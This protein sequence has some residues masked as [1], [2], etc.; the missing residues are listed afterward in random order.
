MS[1]SACSAGQGPDTRAPFQ[2]GAALTKKSPRLLDSTEGSI[3]RVLLS[4]SNY[5]AN[6]FGPALQQVLAS[7]P[8]A[9]RL[10]ILVAPQALDRVSNWLKQS[11][12]GEIACLVEAPDELAFSLWTQDLFLA[13]EDARLELPLHFQRYQDLSA[14]KHLASGAGLEISS[15]SI[16]FEGGNVIPAGDWLLIGKDLVAQNHGDALALARQIDPTRKPVLLGSDMRGAQETR[17]PTG[18]P[19]RGWTETIHWR[20][21]EGSAQPLFHLDLFIAPAGRADDGAPQFLV[22]C[23]RRGAE[24]LGHDVMPHALAD[25]FD[26]I[27]R[28]L[29]EQG[30]NVI[31]NPL[32]L[33]WKDNPKKRER[34][35]FHL[36]TNNVLTEE[37]DKAAKTV[38]LPCFASKA[39]PE[40]QSIDDTNAAIWALLGYSVTRIP[41]L[42]SLAENLG[43]LHC[44]AKVIERS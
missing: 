2:S 25:A 31:R 22:G 37:D 32:P 7:L 20:M 12:P 35:W 5:G 38:W 11:G 21:P 13:Y 17:R 42:M 28:Q 29:A 26:D 6:T 44:M 23:P 10:D 36:P 8:R 3:R 41:G 33:I 43:A 18:R 30:A 40:L 24:L 14:A 27:A 16:Y 1:V 34:F 9:A 19:A 15:S 4:V 39:W